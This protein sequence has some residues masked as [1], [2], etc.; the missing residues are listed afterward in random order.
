MCAF[1]N[2]QYRFG[3]NAIKLAWIHLVAP[4]CGVVTMIHCLT[5]GSRMTDE[6]IGMARKWV[7]R[8]DRTTRF[9][10]EID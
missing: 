5:E 3:R 10:K 9:M 7:E 4:F 6:L 1:K 2:V 8:E